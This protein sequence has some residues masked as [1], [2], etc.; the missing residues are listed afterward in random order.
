MGAL[1]NNA[2]VFKISLAS[3]GVAAGLFWSFG[4]VWQGM[5]AAEVATFV[6]LATCMFV[7]AGK[8]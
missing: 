4:P 8:Y 5:A 3:R 7:G 2:T 1:Q 6:V